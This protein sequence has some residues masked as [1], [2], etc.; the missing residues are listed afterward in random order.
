M[1]VQIACKTMPDAEKAVIMVYNGIKDEIDFIQV[2]Y[3]RIATEG[4]YHAEP[5]T[6]LNEALDRL[7]EKVDIETDNIGVYFNSGKKL[8]VRVFEKAKIDKE[9]YSWKE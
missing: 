1:Y 8:F 4:P 3:V 2:D 6:S 5:F 9:A 7:H